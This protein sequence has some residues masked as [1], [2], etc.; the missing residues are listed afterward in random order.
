MHWVHVECE[1]IPAELYNVLAHPEKFGGSV[2]WNCD[3]CV[4]SAA[5]MEQFVKAYTERI[6]G[7]EDRV[8]G[9]ENCVKD[10][11]K[12]VEKIDEKLKERDTD[13]AKKIK[14]GQDDVFAEMR[15]RELKRMNVVM[16]RVPELDKESPSGRERND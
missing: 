4:A 9:T 16:Y 15:E 3:S 10:L 14:H 1:G 12:K 2:T 6:K 5:K 7:L 13:T 11:D 8:A